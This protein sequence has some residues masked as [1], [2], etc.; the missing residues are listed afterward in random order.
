MPLWDGDGAIIIS[1]LLTIG[2]G[3]WNVV[4]SHLVHEAYDFLYDY[5]LQVP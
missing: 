2:Y 4:M 1:W 3:E 5:S